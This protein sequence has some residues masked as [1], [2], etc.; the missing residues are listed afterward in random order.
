MKFNEP[1][2]YKAQNNTEQKYNARIMK[3][4]RSKEQLHLSEACIRNVYTCASLKAWP[5]MDTAKKIQQ[6]G[7]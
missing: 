2:T 4:R 3:T 6:H 1:G 7:S 5:I